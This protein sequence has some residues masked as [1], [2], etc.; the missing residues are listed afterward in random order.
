MRV[1]DYVMKFL[2][3]QGVKHMFT[4][5]GGG[6]MYLVDALGRSNIKEVCCH[7]EQA[8]GIAAQSYAM[9]RNGLGACLLTTGPG[10][11]NGL[12]ALGAAYMDSTPM[13]FISGQVKTA[14]FA[15]LRKVRQYGAQENDIVAMA[16]PVAKYAVTV[17]KSEEIKYHMEKA[18]FLA[19][20]G[21][22]GPVWVDIPLDIQNDEITP[23]KL[24]GYY[25]EDEVQPN[26]IERQENPDRE[27]IENKI[28][29][30][31]A[32]LK[33]AK[34]PLFLVGHGLYQAD[35]EDTFEQISKYL[36]IP[37]VVTWRCFSLFDDDA[38]LFFGAMGLQAPRYA[39][40]L[41]QTADVLIVLGSRLDNMIT[42]FGESR[43]GLNAKKY[44][45][46][47]DEN[48]LD[49]Y[50]MP[51]L[52]KINASVADFLGI[53]Q[54]KTIKLG[55]ENPKSPYQDWIEK[56]NG[57]K[58]RFPIH[59]EKQAF[60][61]D[62]VDLYKLT[63]AVSDWCKKDDIIVVS[64]T[65]RCNTAG[66]IA[67]RHKKGQRTVSSMGFGSMGFALPSTVGAAFVEGANRVVMFE[68]D[69]SLQL[70]IQE[71]Q[72]IVH[73]KIDAKM[74]IFK[75]NG[76]AAIAT[77]QDRNFDGFHVGS[78][79][80]SGLSMPDTEKIAKAYGI[81]YI[82]INHNEEIETKVEEAFKTNGPVICEFVGD[83][84]FDEIPKCISSLNERGERVSAALENPFPFL[85]EKE[86]EEIIDYIKR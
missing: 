6:A 37:S 26:D 77:M 41:V 79:E 38:P 3:E 74:F 76:Y 85:D 48:E 63:M 25:P 20:H 36:G 13:F 61:T 39:N 55:V 67:F 56:G 62:K 18:L 60:E 21:R 45:V 83:I 59:A 52:I 44:V 58:L 24:T 54:L 30:L 4:L 50:T 14:D 86:L 7:H 31:V 57:L 65:S 19:T 73:H 64:S 33:K 84:R 9:A 35:M 22:K 27:M 23:S 72:T 78:D 40:I 17:T 81:P 82:C 32:D 66:H 75:N 8:A 29:E 53:L 12:T 2:E 16:K 70:N 15:S 11:T 43:F 69:G 5:V 10:G 49:K 51:N 34:R 80:T 28:D 68:G 1:A 42:A 47:I 71:L 46:D